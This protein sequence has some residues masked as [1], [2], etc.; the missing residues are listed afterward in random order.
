[1]VRAVRCL[2]DLLRGLRRLLLGTLGHTAAE[3]QGL[4][5]RPIVVGNGAFER[6]LPGLR[7]AHADT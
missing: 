4:R 6:C 7:T 1:M 3:R 5:E 2:L